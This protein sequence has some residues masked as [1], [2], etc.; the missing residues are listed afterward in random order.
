MRSFMT[1][2]FAK[3][4][5]NDQIKEDEICRSSSKHT[6]WIQARLGWESHK[7]TDHWEDLHL[8]GRLLLQWNL[9][10]ENGVV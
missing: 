3:Y 9:E 5:Y 6:G 8:G 1:V 4:N 10:E 7:E 2:R